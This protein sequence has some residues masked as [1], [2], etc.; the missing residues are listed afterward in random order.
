[1][2]LCCCAQ[3]R[4]LRTVIIIPQRT[5]QEASCSQL[6]LWLLLRLWTVTWCCNEDKNPCAAAFWI[7]SKTLPRFSST[8]AGLIMMIDSTKRRVHIVW[9]CSELLTP[10][11][12]AS[13]HRLCVAW[14]FCLSLVIFSSRRGKTVTDASLL[15]PSGEACMWS[16]GGDVHRTTSGSHHGDSSWVV[17][18]FWID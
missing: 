1:M 18:E 15:S 13:W 16:G 5:V 8:S 2:R 17:E 11:G 14:L 10:L 12:T 4:M 3:R 6:Q 9:V 7:I